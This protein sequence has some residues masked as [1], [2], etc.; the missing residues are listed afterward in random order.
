MI[1]CAQNGEDVVLWR[2]LGHVTG[3]RYVDVRA[4]DPVHLS[5]TKAVYGRGWRGIDIDP[6]PEH[7]RR[8]LGARPGNE[9]V[10]A[11]ITDRP[12]PTVELNEMVGTGLST[13]VRETAEE[14]ERAGFR[15]RSI[16]VPA[17]TMDSVCE[18]S[19]LLEGELHLVKIDFEG[20]ESEVLR[21]FDL[22]R[23]KPWVVLVEATRPL[24]TEP[25]HEGWDP[26]LIDAGY[27]FTMF[28]GLSRHYVSPEHPEFVARLSYPACVLDDFVT[29]RSHELGVRVDALQRH[30]DTKSEVTRWRDDALNYWANSVAQVQVSEERS[31]RMRAEAQR[32]RRQLVRV[33]GTLQE[34]RED[35]N[36]LRGR[37][38]ALAE[39]IEE[40]ER[41]SRSGVRSAR[42]RVGAALKKVVAG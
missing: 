16:E 28:D 42:G 8:L 10:R 17:A 32:A 37:V 9:V 36:R 35:R 12:G 2:A 38:R 26:L 21:S 25:A 29:V 22:R 14:H 20:A 3:G 24:S 13:L 4:C 1:S 33:R 30:V 7:A 27:I 15:R 18:Q 19:H 5:V 6:V 11:A 23:W 40:R 41:R 39:R 31:E 34:V